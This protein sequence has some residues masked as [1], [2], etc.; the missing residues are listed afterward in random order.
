MLLLLVL[1]NRPMLSLIQARGEPSV[2]AVLVDDSMSMQVADAGA[3]ELQ[4]TTRMEAVKA[5]LNQGLLSSLAEKH[6]VR[7][8]RFS[9]GPSTVGIATDND[10]ARKLSKS[11][12]EM[13]PAGQST[14]VRE[15][16]QQVAQ[17]LQGQR[18]AGIVLFS[19]GRE[20]P[21][22]A[23]E[24]LG[25]LGGVRVY[26]VPVGTSSRIR[27][28]SIRSVSN[29]DVAFKGDMIAIRVKLDVTGM[30][31][32]QKVVLRLKDSSGGAI[33][34]AKGA[35]VVSE[36]TVGEEKTYE[37][38]LVMPAKEAKVMDLA[39]EA[40]AVPGEI[41]VDDNSRAL[42]VTVLEATVNLLYVD[43]YPRWD[44]RYLKV[45]MM[46]DKTVEL[47]TILTSAD[48][49]YVQEGDRPIRFFPQNLEQML[50]YDV[51]IIGDVDPR[52][53]TDAQLGMMRDFV[54]KRGG[55]FG[56]VAGPRFSP[57]AWRG[58]PIEAVLPVDISPVASEEPV[59]PFRPVITAEG[60]ESPIFRF[61]ADREVNERYIAEV[62]PKLFW[63]AR[64]L[65][66]RPAVAEVYAEHPTMT[67]PDGR[68]APL[69][70]VGRPGAGRSLFSAIDDSWRWR[71]YTGE[72]IF[73]TYWVQQIRYLARGRKVGQRKLAFASV[74]PVYEAGEQVQLEM[75]VID[76]VLGTQLPDS[77]PVEVYDGN[78]RLVAR[79]NLQR[80]STRRDVFRYLM[81]ATEVG[82]FIAK[83]PSLAPGVDAA[84]ASFDVQIPRLEL[85]D[86]R[87]A[88]THLG[89][90][91]AST[92]GRV[93]EL[94]NAARE[95]AAIPS[96]ARVV[97][98][99]TGWP[100]W[101][102]PLILAVVAVL[103]A[104]EWVMRKFGGMV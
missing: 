85:S 15:S 10:E 67:G 104:A 1:L 66:V 103:L 35:E 101:S 7:L 97:P 55:G 22:T 31:A 99:Q 27:N 52:Q 56:M 63:F 78:G 84:S 5:V 64:G 43:G 90:F 79:E 68:K 2:L 11:V 45:Q 19:D 47:S 91:A 74:R 71:Y 24:Q 53:F 6:Q 36:L 72:S 94:N 4:P 41:T 18:L 102:S 59:E 14:R 29:Q 16:V 69:L 83:I 98:V 13:K 75:R 20:M 82:R 95:L 92:D 42:Q 96:A 9:S 50:E 25:E 62:L 26:P 40:N 23:E 32:G 38:D 28:I 8:Y 76:D 58:T 44:Y 88:R 34:D 3:S 87:P 49:G 100:L 65:S 60:R 12:G 93:I 39:V 81:P 73:D 17:Q 33:T 46:R 51:L 21:A 48:P 89:Q 86:P 70:V 61:F 57:Q 37:T 80:Q 54:M 77:V 30:D